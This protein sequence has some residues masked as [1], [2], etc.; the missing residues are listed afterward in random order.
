LMRHRKQHVAKAKATHFNKE[1]AL[2]TQKMMDDFYLKNATWE[3]NK[4]LKSTR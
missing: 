3:F 2:K 1:A 4:V